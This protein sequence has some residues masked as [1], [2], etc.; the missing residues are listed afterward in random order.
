VNKYQI[1]HS[2][3]LAAIVIQSPIYV[4]ADTFEHYHDVYEFK[5]KEGD[6]WTVVASFPDSV[7]VVMVKRGAEKH[8]SSKRR[9]AKRAAK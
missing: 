7:C 1:T 6:D 4:D 3:R 8:A 5:I 2:H 9:D